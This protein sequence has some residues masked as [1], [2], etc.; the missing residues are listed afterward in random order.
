MEPEYSSSCAVSAV[1][2]FQDI[3]VR[4]NDLH[5]SYSHLHNNQVMNSF[6]YVKSHQD[7]HLQAQFFDFVVY[8]INFPSER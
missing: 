6:Y 2:D 8:A 4:Y 7:V 3:H 1:A 5:Q